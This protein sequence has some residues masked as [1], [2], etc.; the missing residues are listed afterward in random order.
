M[1][2]HCTRVKKTCWERFHYGRKNSIWIMRWFSNENQHFILLYVT[3]GIMS[4]RV[5]EAVTWVYTTAEFFTGLLNSL[6]ADNSLILKSFLEDF[7][8]HSLCPSLIPFW[9]IHSFVC[10]SHLYFHVSFIFT[11]TLMHSFIHCLFS[12]I[13]RKYHSWSIHIY[14][15]ISSLINSLADVWIPSHSL[16]H[17]WSSLY[18][19]PYRKIH[20][21]INTVIFQLS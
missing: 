8:L 10:L 2:T 6:T 1:L 5:M 3:K 19:R 17:L 13:Q 11:F 21:V 20:S 15:L 14:V 18:F 12:F 16:I 7:F 4:Y 9:P